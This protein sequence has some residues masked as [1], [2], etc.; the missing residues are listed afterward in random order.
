MLKSNIENIKTRFKNNELVCE[1]IIH[2]FSLIS[3]KIRFRILCLLLEGDFCVSDIVDIIQIGKLS[4]V[5]QQLKLLTMSGIIEKHRDKKQ[6]IYHIKSEEVKQMIEFLHANY[7]NTEK[8]CEENCDFGS[9]DSR[10]ND[11]KP[12][13]KEN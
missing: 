5:S 6:I 13:L 10:N 2:I 11:G 7:L 1:K 12:P 9:G 3:N 4:N 8:S